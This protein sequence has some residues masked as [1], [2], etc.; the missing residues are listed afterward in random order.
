[1]EIVKTLEK[2]VGPDSVSTSDTI[3]QTYSYSSQL[4]K[5]WVTKPDI[6]VMAETTEQVSRILQVANRH[7]V[8]VTPRGACGVGGHG[9][10]LQGGILL[11][12]TAM[13]KIIKIDVE[14][15]KSIAESGCSFFKLSQELFKKGL[16]LPT[17]E[18][19][20]GPS[21]VASATTPVNAFGK[22]RYG[23]NID[24]VEGFEV[25][26]P[27]GEISRVGSMAYADS[28]MAAY[29]R[30]ITGPDLVGLFTQANGA[31][32][33]ITKIAYR[34]L[35]LPKLWAFHSYYWPLGK[36]DNVTKVLMES[37]AIEMFDVHI[38]D[39][40]KYAG[41]EHAGKVPP[42]PEDCYFIIYFTVNA[43]NDL[44]L[45]GKEQ[46]I[47][48]ICRKHGG[49]YLP[50]IAESFFAVW[51]TF[52]SP[53][54]NPIFSE[55]MN[56]SRETTG[57]NYLSIFD[58]PT[59]P[60]TW[61]PKVYTKLMEI[62]K[63]YGIWGFPR[64]TV[65]DGF[66]MK[67]QVMASQTWTFVDLKDQHWMDLLER[68]RNEFREWYGKKGGVFQSSLPPFVPNYVWTNQPSAHALLKRF[69][70]LLDPNNILSPGTF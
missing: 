44:E 41:L 46:T 16:L 20:P 37:T 29:Y 65:F 35:R 59:Y 64:L 32:G 63:K 38:N 45:K 4:G 27:T 26:L 24:L 10:P 58:G 49:A 7:K 69:K 11:D 13:E 40:W 8:P 6:V 34:C 48:D 53:V 21:V 1:M 52:F 12:L 57:G 51:P 54:T 36:I 43:E 70:G 50:D 19:G 5:A 15:M 61:F 31:F 18:Y 68:Y 66:A 42:L 67:S 3:C 60:L 25:V 62:G 56:V 14:N 55:L 30:Y 22:T 23:R 33:V 17:A 9:G 28:D 39:R 2:I 47:E